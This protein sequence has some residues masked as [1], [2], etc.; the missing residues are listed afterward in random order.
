M[1]RIFVWFWWLAI[2]WFFVTVGAVRVVFGAQTDERVRASAPL[3]VQQIT[4][5]SIENLPTK[6]KLKPAAIT[7]AKETEE[8]QERISSSEF[9]T[10]INS[11]LPSFRSNLS[12]IPGNVSFIPANVSYKGTEELKTANTRTFQNAVRDTEG[13]I[14]YDSVG[15]DLD[16]TFSLRGFSEGS[17]VIV[18]VDGVRVNELD[19]DAVNYPLIPMNDVES[20]QINRGSASPVY[21]SGAFAGVV[22]IMTRRSSPKRLNLFGGTEVSSFKG[23]RFN[24]G[25]SGTI[26]DRLTPIEGS[27]T[28]YFNM[29]RDLN[30]GFRDNGEW[31]I[32][33]LDGKLSYEL[34]DNGGRIYG[35]IKHVKDAVSNPGP[36]TVPEY[37]R[38]PWQS[39][40][41][42][43]GRD[44]RNTIIQMG[45]DKNFFGNRLIASILA[46]WRVNLIHFYTTSRTF[47]DGAFNP[48]TDLVTTKSRTTDLIWQIGYEDTWK[49][50]SERS[51]VGMEFRNASELDVEQDAFRGNVVETSPR[52]TER[53]AK[54]HSTAIF[55]RETVKFYERIIAHVGMRHDL[56]WLRATDFITPTNSIS[57][58][59]RD[60]SLSTGLTLKPFEFVDIFGNYSQGFRVPTISDIAPFAGTVSTNLRPEQTDSYET[61]TRLRYKN[62]VQAKSS[63]FLIDLKDEIV[64][65]STLITP[66]TPFGGNANVGES[67]RLGIESRL[68]LT[69]VQMVSFYGSYTWMKAYVRASSSDPI[70]SGSPFVGRDFGLVPRH[71]FTMGGAIKPLQRFGVPF[72]GLRIGIDGTYTGRQF[73]QSFESSTQDLLDAA[74][75]KF[76]GY[77]IW[78]GSISFEWKGQR[79]YFRINNL[80]DK[81]YYSRAVAATAGAPAFGIPAPNG[82][83]TGTHLFVNPGAP[84]EYILGMTWEFGD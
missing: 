61:G 68:D 22:N 25:M 46:S 11:R 53:N 49:W 30:E 8:S 39:R 31:R 7:V 59:W 47:P 5:S 21:G 76:D 27:V 33:S 37:Y 74:G 84:R 63:F 67:R 3:P 60:S 71:R 62:F 43:D 40:N 29:G 17:A 72:D 24:E 45:A 48:D 15:N 56:A 23:I 26:P 6:R 13:A 12:D 50:F 44:F 73:F 57:R 14:F 78:D 28:Y 1:N 2:L 80:F 18:L 38:D 55:W 83:A 16:T 69:P 9:P 82:T 77:M 42:L 19:G 51:E 34:P 70:S 35:G 64:N 66:T 81:R 4:A 36:L 58:R 10:V 20:I 41:P 52:E 32:T 75:E 65:D 54:P 79:I